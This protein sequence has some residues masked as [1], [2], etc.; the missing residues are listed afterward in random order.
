MEGVVPS[1]L[2]ASCQLRRPRGR[3][4][5]CELTPRDVRTRPH[6]HAEPFPAATSHLPPLVHTCTRAL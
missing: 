5:I 2:P 1:L 3:E 6:V 4:P